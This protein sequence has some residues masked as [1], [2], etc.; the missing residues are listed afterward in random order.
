MKRRLLAVVLAVAAFGGAAVALAEATV[1]VQVR[2]A[3]GNVDGTVT[4]TA[5]GR[6]FSC[7]T[8]HGACTIPGVPGGSASASFAPDGGGAA[9]PARTVMIAP[10]GDVQLI[11]SAGR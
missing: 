1:H 8:Q 4:L 7:H 9:P 5:A 2:A 11:L 10:S 6:T 3:Q